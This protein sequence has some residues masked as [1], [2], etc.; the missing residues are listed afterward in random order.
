[1][2]IAAGDFVVVAIA[3]RGPSTLNA[4][5]DLNSHQF[6]RAIQSQITATGV[7]TTSAIY[8]V[9]AAPATMQVVNVD[10]TGGVTQTVIVS[11]WHCGA[12]PSGLSRTGMTSGASSGT[13]TDT[14]DLMPPSRSLVVASLTGVSNAGEV[15]QTPGFTLLDQVSQSGTNGSSTNIAVWGVVQGGTDVDVT[16]S[17][18]SGSPFAGTA[19]AFTVQ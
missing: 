16:F 14:G 10:W 9:V 12:P 13:S 18:L 5:S 7:M 15:V 19:A 3:G 4:V 1:M 8:Y 11:E 2:P 17:T 6:A